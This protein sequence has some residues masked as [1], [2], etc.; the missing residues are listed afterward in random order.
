MNCQ[1]ANFSV[2]QVNFR[3]FTLAAPSGLISNIFIAPIPLFTGGGNMTL[4]AQDIELPFFGS[5]S[6]TLSDIN[7]AA[8]AGVAYAN[9]GVLNTFQAVPQT[10]SLATFTG[11]NVGSTTTYTGSSFGS[12]IAMDPSRAASAGSISG[13]GGVLT[14][15]PTSL[16]ASGQ[17]VE[18]SPAG[19]LGGMSINVR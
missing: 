11:A 15:E 8:V 13:Q 12:R 5:G 14:I 19:S 16:L 10:E 9:L 1:P 4:S 6:I 18:F 2:P 3:D 7:T 17:T